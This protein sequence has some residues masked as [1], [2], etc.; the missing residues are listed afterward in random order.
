MGYQYEVKN[1]KW[2]KLRDEKNTY[3]YT[4]TYE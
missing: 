4:V 2:T 1:E 3:T